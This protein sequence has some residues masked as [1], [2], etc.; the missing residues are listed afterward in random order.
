MKQHRYITVNTGWFLL[1][2][3]LLVACRREET[4]PLDFNSPEL[5]WDPADSNAVNAQAYLRGVYGTLPGGFNRIAGDF[6]DNAA[7][8]AVT[9]RNTVT[10]TTVAFFTN[11]ALTA[12]NYP[13]NY[14]SR[15][16]AGIRS[17]NIFLTNIDKVP[18]RA[19]A[20]TRNK[21]WKAEVRFIRALHYWELV[22]RYGG[23]PLIGDN[24]FNYTDNLQLPR[25]TFEA[26]VNYIVS[27]CDAIKEDLRAVGAIADAELGNIHKSCAVALKMRVQLY[28]ASPLFNGGGVSGDANR[29]ALTGFTTADPG[30]WQKVI[31]TYNEFNSL[32]YYNLNTTFFNVFNAKKNTEVILAKQS[33]NNFDLELSQ[34]PVGFT[35]PNVSLGQTSPTQELV[36]AFPTLKGGTITEDIKTAGNPTGYDA[37]SPYVNRDPR[38]GWTVFF[39][40]TMWQRRPVETFEGG[41][42]KPNAINTTQTRTGYYLR[43]FLGDFGNATAYSNQSHNFPLFRYAEIIL[44]YAEALNEMGRTEDAV[45]QIG[46]LRKR[47]GITAGSPARYGIKTSITQEEMRT[48]IQNERR[49][50]LAFEEHRFYDIR[51]WKIAPQVLQGNM[52][53]VTITKDPVGGTLTYT[54]N[55]PVEA[56]SF[57][58]RLYYMP[59][60]YDEVLKNP[61]LVQN[62]GW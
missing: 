36:N 21:A 39:N 11:G 2:L 45:T 17:A 6:L 9:S 14:W 7:G 60:P 18:V 28:A 8:E 48:L 15:G 58:N 42:D 29:K 56:M 49:I 59:L 55:K 61:N 19:A 54:Y 37:A 34:S 1:L 51:R 4:E 62:E 12:N 26:C 33:P 44:N 24:V 52:T 43:K 57:N 47:A 20:P 10:G 27:E 16:Y 40:G 31:D 25:N 50:E 46:L 23:V 38:L 53:G 5:V 3:T 22:K 30:R 35:A 32:G 13:D 41:K